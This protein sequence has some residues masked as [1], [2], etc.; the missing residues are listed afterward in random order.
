[1]EINQKAKDSIIDYVMEKNLKSTLQEMPKR[2]RYE[3]EF[4]YKLCVNEQAPNSIFVMS[5]V[6]GYHN[7]SL[8][9]SKYRIY[10]FDLNGKPKNNNYQD[11]NACYNGFINDLK[12][13]QTII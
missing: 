12:L 1:M 9:Y 2:G 4:G 10:E 3:V 7:H 11:S 8:D 13:V 6:L 5:E